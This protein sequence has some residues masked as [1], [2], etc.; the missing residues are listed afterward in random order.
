[1]KRRQ[2]DPL[3]M[4]GTTTSK[5][6]PPIGKILLGCGC[7]TLLV[8]GII[9][10]ALAIMVYSAGEQAAK[11]L[12]DEYSISD[13]ISVAMGGAEAVP[14]EVAEAAKGTGDDAK[15]G[16]SASS[17]KPRKDKTELTPAKVRAAIQRPLTQKDVDRVFGIY[18]GL[19]KTDAYKQWNAS[20]DSMKNAGKEKDKGTL[21]RMKMMRNGMKGFDAYQELFKEYDRLVKKAG[22]YDEYLAS[23][24]RMSGP[25]A[26]AKQIA[27]DHKKDKPESDEV[28]ALILKELPEVKKEFQKTAAEAK[29]IA[30]KNDGKQAFNPAALMMLQQPGTIAMGRMPK[31]SFET[32]KK[33]SEKQRK[34]IIDLPKN[35]A[36]D[37]PGM[38][39]GVTWSGE[40]LIISSELETFAKK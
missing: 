34:E 4:A 22:G 24:V 25:A 7:L 28:A 8:G 15:S 32:W 14:P 12:G 37:F 39:I 27:K 2:L 6:G 33:F 40:P 36:K 19:R 11:K 20:L 38:L 35:S 9:A 1:M 13:A 10:A 26:A 21:E 23:L 29:K 31:K 16:S 18:E 5:S 30:A 17:A 3:V